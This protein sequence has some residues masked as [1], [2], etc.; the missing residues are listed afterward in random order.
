MKNLI[1]YIIIIASAL[2]LASCSFDDMNL[3]DAGKEEC[4]EYVAKLANYSG[5]NVTTRPTKAVPSRTEPTELETRIVSAYFMVF[6]SDNERISIKQVAVQDNQIVPEKLSHNFSNGPLTICY[7]VNV[8]ESYADSLDNLT[9]FSN[10]AF[11][12]KMSYADPTIEGN[13]IGTPVLNGTQCFP[14]L[15]MITQTYENGLLTGVD[16][17]EGK[18]V[19]T[20]PLRRLFAKIF[21]QVSWETQINTDNLLADQG[22]KLKNYSISNL[23]KYVLMA[24]IEENSESDW[25]S[26]DS[27]FSN[28]ITISQSSETGL[29]SSIEFTLY[30][31][32]YVLLPEATEVNK[33]IDKSDAEKQKFKPTLFDTDK[34]PVYLTIDGIVSSTDF[35]DVPL[36]YT[37]YL[38]EN[39]FENFSVKRNIQYNNIITITG[40]GDA[41]LGNDH[42]VEA[43]YHN[44]ADPNN[45]NHD[46]PANCYIIGRPG[47][48]LIPTYKGATTE[49]ML[50]DIDISKT[51]IHSDGKNSITNLEFIPD[52]ADRNWIMFD[53]NMSIA[54]NAIS[55]LPKIEDGNTVMEFKKT[56]GTTVWSWHLWFTSGGTLGSEWGAISKETYSTKAD[57]MTHN[58]GSAESGSNGMYYLWGDKDPYFTP[59]GKSS[60]YYGNTPAG[61]WAGTKKSVTDP[62]PPGYKVPSNAVWLGNS[63]W[64]ATTAGADGAQAYSGSGFFYDLNDPN[65][66]YPFSS[67]M[68]G[69]TKV[70][71]SP[72]EWSAEK[73]EKYLGQ[74]WYYQEQYTLFDGLIWTIDS[75]KH[76]HYGVD[77]IST[78]VTSVDTRLGKIGPGHWLWSQSTADKVLEIV[79]RGDKAVYENPGTTTTLDASSGLQVRCVSE[80]SEVK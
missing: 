33:H 69:N 35:V 8:R 71:H 45:T 49:V 80:K 48:Y 78:K 50:G 75:N 44:L 14:M 53:V 55:S 56:D 62:C 39:A 52:Y 6:G 47:R 26:D 51:V 13:I 36:I 2:M 9:K 12:Y 17:N 40:T 65:V 15:G 74:T 79:S 28:P 77:K 24:E 37:I 64:K 27:Y 5:Y 57:M 16:L 25:V 22:F 7:L 10:P 76:L 72:S 21:V 46:T 11:A 67:Y 54:N 42:R 61:S 43:L 3:T 1:K 18:Y 4:V 70:T 59:S 29:L 73:S 31:P 20:I 66:I 23:P 58:I 63:A 60:G 38:G 19:S 32:E 34:N 41:I 68:N 30:S